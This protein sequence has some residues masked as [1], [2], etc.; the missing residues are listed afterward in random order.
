MLFGRYGRYI[1]G[2]LSTARH[3][4]APV[5]AVRFEPIEPL[6][7][8]EYV[9]EQLRRHLG[10]GL[11]AAGRVLPSER[12]LATMFG[13]GRATIQAALRLLAAQGLV[14]SR[15]GRGGGTFV[16]EPAR[17]EAA[18]QRL[19]LEVKLARAEIEDA[20]RFRRVIEEG[21]VRQA[22]AQATE[23]DVARLN[24]LREKMRTARSDLEFHRLDTE[25]HV[26][27]GQA[28]A[29]KLLR[30]ATERARLELNNAIL[31]LPESDVWHE[32]SDREHE[33][34]MNAVAAHD[35]RAAV[36]AMSR[37]LAH[38]EQAIAALLAALS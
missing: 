21:V 24:R 3:V 19:L 36:R 9:A 18:H 16:V 23:A 27:L 38:T 37:H 2:V 29:S 4:N 13:V 32:R 14:E 11:I 12:E 1:R 10:L 5:A 22:S 17:D 28:S 7:A 25:F 26:Q 35:Q 8:H 15:R 20:L 6:R 34:I 33:R 30:A 31:A